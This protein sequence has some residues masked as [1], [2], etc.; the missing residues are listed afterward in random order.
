MVLSCFPK[1]YYAFWIYLYSIEQSF[2]ASDNWTELEIVSAHSTEITV[3]KQPT[4]SYRDGLAHTLSVERLT[5]RVIDAL[6]LHGSIF[7]AHTTDQ[8]KQQFSHAKCIQGISRL[9]TEAVT[10]Q[11]DTE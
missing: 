11:T 5:S 2:C 7:S 3:L 10:M 9:I 8:H 1:H 6:S 4:S